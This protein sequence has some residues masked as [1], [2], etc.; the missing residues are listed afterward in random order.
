ME[1]TIASG[2]RTADQEAKYDAAC[3]RLL[4]EK[5]ILAWI[6]KTCVREFNDYTT[7]D[8]AEHYIEGQPEVGTVPVS[9]D[10]TNGGRISGTGVEDPSVTEGTVTYDIRFSA[11]VPVSGEVIRLI[12]NVEAQNDFY[13]GYP[14]LKRAIYYCGRMISSQYGT[15]FTKAHYEKVKKVYSIWI[16]FNPPK[17]RQ[18]TITSYSMM[19]HN[20]AGDVHEPTAHYDLMTAVIICLGKPGDRNYGGILKLL[21]VLFS[22]EAGYQERREVLEN[23]FDIPMTQTIEREVDQMCNL[24]KGI[25][26]KG[27]D[28]GK[29]IMLTENIRNIMNALKIPVDQAMELLNVPDAERGKYAAMIKK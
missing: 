11:V 22:D 8:I 7:K 27:V 4:S 9:P 12:I 28:Q 14:L 15:E 17:K 3:K 21:D 13:P 6:L 23:E 1:T 20:L 10:E 29:E 26:D 16:C 19:E 24:S 2:M 25:L 5:I 18:N